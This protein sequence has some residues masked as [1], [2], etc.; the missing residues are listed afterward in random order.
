MMPKRGMTE[1]EETEADTD[2]VIEIKATKEIEAIQAD[3]SLI[4]WLYLLQ[5][6]LLNEIN[7]I[8]PLVEISMG[9]QLQRKG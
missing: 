5:L 2:E 7:H 9:N 6:H 1:G 4:Y 3:P 8:L